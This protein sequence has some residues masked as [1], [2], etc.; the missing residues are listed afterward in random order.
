MQNPSEFANRTILIVDDDRFSRAL[1]R[2]IC[3]QLG[4]GRILL[5]ADGVEA[6]EACRARNP[7]VVLS[8]LLMPGI[9]GLG[10]LER[11]RSGRGAAPDRDVPVVFLSGAATEAALKRAMVVGVDRCLAKPPSVDRV[12]RSLRA[13]LL[14]R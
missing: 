4:F 9:D 11:V 10:F 8:D 5:A 7:D 13:A 2:E 14:G 6:L 12:R 3:V 1:V